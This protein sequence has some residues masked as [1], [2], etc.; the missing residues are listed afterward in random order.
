M[1]WCCWFCGH[2][3]CSFSGCLLWCKANIFLI[4]V[5]NPLLLRCR[6]L[7]YSCWFRT[8]FRLFF[9]IFKKIIFFYNRLCYDDLFYLLNCFFFHLWWWILLIIKKSFLFCCRLWLRNL[10]YFFNWL[11]FFDWFYTHLLIIIKNSSFFW[12]LY[13]HRNLNCNFRLLFWFNDNL[14]LF[15]I[16][17]VLF[18]FFNCLLGS[19]IDLFWNRNW[20][21]LLVIIK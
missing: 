17:K 13:F 16:I 19:N 11:L 21:S 18:G 14:F 5:K 2:I 12:L 10:L 4:I 9:I 15:V 20:S 3:R 7:R 1:R 8:R 6:R